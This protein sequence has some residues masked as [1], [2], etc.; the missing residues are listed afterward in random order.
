MSKKII[1]FHLNDEVVS[2]T[3][4]TNLEKHRIAAVTYKNGSKWWQDAWNSEKRHGVCTG[5]YENGA[6]K[7]ETTWFNGEKHGADIWWDKSGTMRRKEMWNN[8]ASLGLDTGWYESG[9]KE[10][11]VYYV[12]NKEYARIEWDEAGNITKTKLTQG[13]SYQEADELIYV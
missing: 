2:K 13:L 6:K 12:H 4:Q 9:W 7:Y 10:K 1:K 11:E 5:W 8:G 3:T